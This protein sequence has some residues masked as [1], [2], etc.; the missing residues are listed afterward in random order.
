MKMN[1]QGDLNF[2]EVSS[3]PK[4][5]K[6]VATGVITHS[7]STSHT[8]RLVGGVLFQTK[9]GKQYADVK[10]KAT[11]KHEEHGAITL[12]KGY[13]EIRRQREYTMKDATKIVV[14]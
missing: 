7:D 14:D 10:T 11:V 8:H 1:R 13:W 9:D 2:L 4:G 12:S 5:V 3:I 6:K